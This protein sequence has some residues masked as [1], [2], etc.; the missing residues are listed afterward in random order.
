MR[1]YKV[2]KDSV[3]GY[4]YIDKMIC[5]KIIDT[6]TFQRLRRIEQ[7]SMRCLYPAASHDRFI[8]S[9]GVYNLSQIALKSIGENIKQNAEKLNDVVPEP[10][11]RKKINFCFGMAAILHDVGHAPFSHTLEEFF[12]IESLEDAE[13][14]D[15]ARIRRKR[16]LIKKLCD[17]IRCYKKDIG[18]DDDQIE[19]EDTILSVDLSSANPAPHEI[20]SA[21][22]VLRV[23]KKAI[24][25]IAVDQQLDSKVSFELIARCITGAQYKEKS[26][27]GKETGYSNCIIRLLNSTIDIDKLDY[28]SRDSNISGYDN[29]KIDIYRLLRALVVCLYKNSENE[30]CLTLAFGKN[31]ISVVENVILSRNSLYTW[32]YAHH[33]IKYETY[34]IQEAIKKIADSKIDEEKMEFFQKYFSMDAVLNDLICDADIWCLLKQERKDELI[35]QIFD[36]R[37]QRKAIWKSFSEF[38]ILFGPSEYGDIGSFSVKRMRKVLA[39]DTE[40]A[41]FKEYLNIFG[42]KKCKDYKGVDVIVHNVKLTYIKP[43][44]ILIY[45]NNQLYGYDSVVRD[46]YHNPVCEAFFYL[47]YDKNDI[48]KIDKQELVQYIKKYS[49]FNLQPNFV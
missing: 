49:K 33:K 25:E 35:N 44:S 47:F 18:I 22:V 27:F 21:L 14:T 31:A 20:M 38:N 1:Q 11:E 30:E 46:L 41:A 32:I 28:I 16:N 34:L 6:D 23:F 2:I 8:H 43:N 4:I 37:T 42:A 45:L 29:V 39:D 19:K 15:N 7:T 40:K 12:G 17:E 13:D 9:I 26:T 3:H 24:V 48:G 36:R 5:E 10:A